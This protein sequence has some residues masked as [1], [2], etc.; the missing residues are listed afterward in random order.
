M[1]CPRRCCSRRLVLAAFL[2]LV[3]LLSIA[4]RLRLSGH[5]LTLASEATHQPPDPGGRHRQ[6][7][8]AGKRGGAG[9]SLD[10]KGGDSGSLGGVKSG[11]SGPLGVKGGDSGPLG[12]KGGDAGSAGVKG[13]DAGS[14]GVKND[15]GSGVKSDAGSGV[16]N[17]AGSGVKN[18][19]GSG[20]NLQVLPVSKI[21]GVTP[22]NPCPE[23]PPIN[24]KLFV[25]P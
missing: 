16:K 18:D 10:V 6:S 25:Q 4:L 13:G 7:A 2:T 21:T 11:D 24:G 12:V 5:L 8:A 14:A 9:G 23:E 22:M 19:A 15:A 3:V 17:D 1:A 20:V